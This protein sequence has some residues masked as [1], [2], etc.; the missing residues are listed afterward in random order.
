[1]RLLSKQVQWGFH[2]IRSKS[3]QEAKSGQKGG[4]LAQE[5]SNAYLRHKARHRGAQEL[6]MWVWPWLNHCRVAPNQRSMI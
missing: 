2:A 5:V 4:G 3:S 1:M 6:K